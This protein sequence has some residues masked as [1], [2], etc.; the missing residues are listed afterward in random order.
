MSNKCPTCSQTGAE[1]T[2]PHGEARGSESAIRNATE[3]ALA[4]LRKVEA[5]N[6]PDVLKPAT[7]SEAILKCRWPALRGEWRQRVGKEKPRNL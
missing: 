4:S 7:A 1:R 2:N 3:L 5:A 6:L